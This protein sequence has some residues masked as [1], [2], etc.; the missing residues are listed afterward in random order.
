MKALVLCGGKPQIALIHELKRRNITAILADANDKAAAVQY[1]DVFYNVSTLDVVGIEKI[2]LAEKVDCILSVCA[3]QMLLVAAQL[4]EKLNLPC[5]IDYETA[6]NVSSKEYMKR[7]FVENNIP[8]AKYIVGSSIS[9]SV[10]E[11]LNF[12]LI[13]KP[14]DCYSSRGVKK[15]LNYD[16]LLSAFENAKNL[17]RTGTVIVEEFVEGLELSV[18]IYVE[19]GKVNILCI[20][21][22]D[23]IPNSEKFIICR[24]NYPAKISLATKGRVQDVAQKI[25]EA[26]GLVDTP[27]LIQ[28]KINDEQIHIL[29]FCA[30]TGGGIKY[31]LLPKVCGFDVVK[32]VLDLTLGE[33][34]HV[35]IKPLNT[36]IVDEFLYC[37]PGILDHTEGFEE[38]LKDGII[39]HYEVYKS[40]GYQ[41][42]E[43]SSSGDR[44]AYFSVVAD[45]EAELRRKHQIAASVVKAVDN[46]G[47]DLIRHDIINI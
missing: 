29:E 1:A 9:L 10:I 20:R 32:A 40:A 24:G 34:P 15:V 7:I 30:R 17:S 14:V 16:E 11:G 23:K 25:V 12:P 39:D 27:M 47:K 13:V 36:F 4:S 28:M 19:N 3:D 22:L 41:F 43:I 8:T 2:A 6:K 35:N 45:T 37:N 38:L 42:D 5:Y 46:K 18:D 33:K 31:R 44:V 26:F 21:S